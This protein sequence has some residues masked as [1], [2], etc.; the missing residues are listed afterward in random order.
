MDT[1]DCNDTSTNCTNI[2]GSFDCVCLPGYHEPDGQS[3]Q[4]M[5]LKKTK[6]TCT[7]IKPR[8]HDS[9]EVN[10][11]SN[12]SLNECDPNAECTDIPGSYLCDCHAGYEGNGTSCSGDVTACIATQ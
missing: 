8:M 12:S 6:K 1:D 4:R 3:C 9:T 10:E 5:I 11:C 7:L 2:P